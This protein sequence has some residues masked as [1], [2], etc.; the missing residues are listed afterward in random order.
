ML[1]RYKDFTL[2]LELNRDTFIE[3]PR[4]EQRQW[5]VDRA[6]GELVDQLRHWDSLAPTLVTGTSR[7]S[8]EGTWSTAGAT[9]TEDE[10]L[11]EGQEVMQDWEWPLMQR[12]ADRVAGSHGDVL[13]IGFGMGISATMMQEIGVRSHTIVELN[14]EVGQLAREWRARRPDADIEIVSGSWRDVLPTLGTFDGILWDAFPISDTEF[15]Q[16]VLRDSTVAESFFPEASAHL[17]P[18]GTFSYYS[19]EVDSLSRTH[20]RS[21]LRYFDR[22]EVEVVGGMQPPEDCQYWWNDTMAVVS[23]KKNPVTR[24]GREAA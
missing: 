10:L 24:N 6:I 21:L 17:R 16:I 9:R 13:E 7:G 4:A 2:A 5:F 20:Q 23:A 19:N 8:V 11:I 1:R 18:G 22:F 3:T 14:E 15:N 12:I